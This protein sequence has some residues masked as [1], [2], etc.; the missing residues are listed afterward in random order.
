VKSCEFCDQ[1]AQY[2]DR[3]TGH[4]VC[5][6]HA[7][8][9]VIAA[10]QHELA[11]P[12]TIRPAGPADY[13]RIEELALYF[14]GETT[15]DCFGRQY[16]VLTCPAFLACN[17]DEVV[18]MLSFS[19]EEQWDAVMVVMLNILP[20]WQGQDG[21]RGLLTAMHEDAKKRTL[22]RLL[23]ATSNDDLPALALYQRYGFRIVE[24]IP[25]LL[26]RHHSGEFPGFSGILI[27]DEIRLSFEVEL[28]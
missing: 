22:G 6:D 19:F 13:C 3:H 12:L 27:R 10:G 28:Q 15:V 23:V 2:R 16:D 5:L 7:R 8:L 9:E 18:G 20:D 26:A 11:M 17:G 25:G 21:G 24:V 1:N 14:W 4:Y